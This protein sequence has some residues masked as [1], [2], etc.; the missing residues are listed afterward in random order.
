MLAPSG[1]AVFPA[2]GDPAKFRLDGRC[3][4]RPPLI[5]WVGYWKAFDSLIQYGRGNSALPLWW[6]GELVPDGWDRARRAVWALSHVSTGAWVLASE[7]NPT[8]A[9]A[10]DF[11]HLLV[12]MGLAERAI[13]MDDDQYGITRERNPPYAQ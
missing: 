3:A 7:P 1:V 4:S 5:R 2:E 6:K 11:A 9:Q 13:L 8:V 10:V 12:E